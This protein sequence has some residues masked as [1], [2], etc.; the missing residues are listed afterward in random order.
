[1][2]PKAEESLGRAA[3]NEVARSESAAR[4]QERS[5]NQPAA[6]LVAARAAADAAGARPAAGF[7]VVAPNPRIRWRVGPGPI[8]QYS[9]DGGAT[10]APQQTG[11]SAELTAGSSPA[12]EVCWLVGR[13]G[14]VLRT[15]DGGRQWQRMAFPETVDLT[16]VTASTALNAI[17]YLADGRRLATTDGGQTWVPVR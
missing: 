16:A 17:V 14:I 9:A 2:A 15:S 6:P 10:W 8:V 7:E 13:G 5:L 3:P 12:L 11:A 4:E 1:V